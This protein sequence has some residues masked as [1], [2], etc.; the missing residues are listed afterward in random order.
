MNDVVRAQISDASR[1]VGEQV[2]RI[3]AELMDE[4]RPGARS[5]SAVTLESVLDKDL[6]LDSLSRVELLLRIE[7]HFHIRLPPHVL[8]HA[9]TLADIVREIT[10]LIGAELAAMDRAPAPTAM[11]HLNEPVPEVCATLPEVLAWHAAQHGDRTHLTLLDDNDVPKAMTYAEL[12]SGATAVAQRLLEAGVGRGDRVAIML[13]TSHAFFWTFAGIQYAGAVP[14]PIYPPF[15]LAQLEEHLRRQTGILTSCGAVLLVTVPEARSVAQLL[16]ATV[17]TL[18]AIIALDDAVTHDRQLARIAP[19][20]DRTDTAFLQYTSGSTGNPKGVVLSHSNVIANI[21]AIGREISVDTSDV[22]VSWL[23]LY[24]D[25]GLIGAWLG[26]LYHAMH[27]VVMSPTAFLSRP[28]RWLWAIHRYRG[29]ISAAPNFAYEMCATKID[30]ERL[31][32]LDLSS[33]RVAFNGAEPVSA[34]TLERFLARF[35]PFGFDRRTMSPVY[36]LAECSLGLTFPPLGRGPLIDHV[37]RHALLREGRAIAVSSATADAMR[38]VA[39]GHVLNG[40]SLRIVTD[41]GDDVPERMVGR[42]QFR[43]PSA[44]RGYF[45]NPEATATLMRGEWLDTGDLGYVGEGDLYPVSRVKDMIIRGGVNLYPYELEEAVGALP[46]VRKGCVAVI[47]V[48]DT[49]S[50][51]ERVVVLAETRSTASEQAQPLTAAINQLAIDL[52]GSPADDVR[53]LPPHSVLKTSSGKIRRAACRDLYVNGRIGDMQTHPWRFAI[54]SATELLRVHARQTL[55]RVGDWLYAGYA[56]LIVTLLAL[57]A[58]LIMILAPM[59]TARQSL[60]ALARA[61]FRML[62]IALHGHGSL[63]PPTEPA[64]LLANHASY[65]DGVALFAMLPDG[66]TFVVKRD[67]AQQRLIAKGLKIAGVRY[68]ERFTHASGADETEELAKAVAN[69]ESLV[70]FPEGTFQRAAGIMPF[71]L[72]AFMVAARTGCTVLPAAIRGTRHI[73]PEGRWLPRRGTVEFRVGEPL[74]PTGRDWG[75]AVQLRDAARA[76]MLQLSGEPDLGTAP[77]SRPAPEI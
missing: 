31:Q 10:P 58:G 29:T 39:C 24:H 13:P 21:R 18:R 59:A 40:H 67:L 74:I 4:L 61:G 72:G 53:L 50:G 69:G 28:E 12:A 3:A 35:R 19:A 22:F 32:G 15:R 66:F 51:T 23:P 42:I 47:G 45:N 16:H 62:G 7:R 30:T 63:A 57:V 48:P 8:E 76:Q 71:Y 9:E 54:R 37:D 43:G 38:V 55:R 1:E 6:S 49:A 26:S 56:T 27:L 11:A 44:T 52:L 41:T 73:L 5:T 68:V 46:G 14:V 17:P 65:L 2:Q 34:D 25:M 33:W 70:F 36:G 75:A 64:L 20:A 77:L 60:R